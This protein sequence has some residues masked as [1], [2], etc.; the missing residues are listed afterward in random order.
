MGRWRARESGRK[1]GGREAERGEGRKEETGEEE[2][3]ERGKYEEGRKGGKEGM[4]RTFFPRGDVSLVMTVSFSFPPI[5]ASRG[6]RE[7]KCSAGLAMVAEQ[8]IN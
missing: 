2:G 1:G 8:Q 7:E 6:R 5:T 3:M 4:T